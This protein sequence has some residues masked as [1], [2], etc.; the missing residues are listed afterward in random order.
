M[1][2]TLRRTSAISV[3]CRGKTLRGA[4]RITIA[5][6]APLLNS[7]QGVRGAGFWR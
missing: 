3:R 2:A 6:V 4:R 1:P 5:A 7:R